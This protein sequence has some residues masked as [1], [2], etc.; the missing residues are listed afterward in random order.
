MIIDTDFSEESLGALQNSPRWRVGGYASANVSVVADGENQALACSGGI[1]RYVRETGGPESAHQRA[2]ALFRFAAEPTEM[3]LIARFI[4]DN[5]HVLAKIH[6][7][8]KSAGIYEVIGGYP[9]EIGTIAWSGG[10]ADAASL[11]MEVV[12]RRVRLWYE[13]ADRPV[14][15]RPP[16]LAADLTREPDSGE[17]GIYFSGGGNMRLLS[18]SARDIPSVV[19]PPPS[20]SYANASGLSLNFAAFTAGVSGVSGNCTDIEWEVY[21]AD[22]VDFPEA[23][24]DRTAPSVTTRTLWGRPGFAYD[25]R[26]REWMNDGSPGPWTD[27][28]RVLLPGDR[29]G[30]L[31]P[32]L[33][34]IEFPD[35]IPD[36]VLIREQTASVNATISE[37]GHERVLSRQARPRNGFKFVFQNRLHDECQLLIDFF[38]EMR[39]KKEPFAWT[40]PTNGEQFALRFD[41][42]NYEIRYDEHGDAGSIVYLAFDVMEVHIGQISTV[43]VSIGDPGQR[44]PI[45]IDSDC[46]V[47]WNNNLAAVPQSGGSPVARS[48]PSGTIL[49]RDEY[50]DLSQKV[51]SLSQKYVTDPRDPD[52]YVNYQHQSIAS[53]SDV[54]QERLDALRL[55]LQ[56]MRYLRLPLSFANHRYAT[57]WLTKTTYNDDED[58][59]V[60][61]GHIDAKWGTP[62]SLY[63]DD[64]SVYPSAGQTGSGLYLYK[65]K[66]GETDLDMEAKSLNCQP[67]FD[68]SSYAD[69]TS[70][71]VFIRAVATD[72]YGYE[73]EENTP[74]VTFHDILN[75]GANKWHRLHSLGE[76]IMGTAWLGDVLPSLGT[77]LGGSPEYDDT[78]VVP[79]SV[80]R[81]DAPASE[82]ASLTVTNDHRTTISGADPAGFVAS[83][84][85]G[86]EAFGSLTYSNTSVFDITPA[87]GAS[88][89]YVVRGQSTLTDITFK[90]CLVSNSGQLAFLVEQTSADLLLFSMVAS[91]ARFSIDAT[92]GTINDVV[93]DACSGDVEL[94]SVAGR[95]IKNCWLNRHEGQ[96]SDLTGIGINVIRGLPVGLTA[97]PPPPIARPP[98]YPDANEVMVL[99]WK[100]KDGCVLIKVKQ[101]V[102]CGYLSSPAEMP[103]TT[104]TA[105][106]AG[107]MPS[108]LAIQG[109][110]PTW[111][112]GLAFPWLYFAESNIEEETFTG[113]MPKT[114]DYEWEWGGSGLIGVY[115]YGYVRVRV[116]LDT[117]L[118]CWRMCVRNSTSVSGVGWYYE[119][120][121]TKPLGNG[122][123]GTYTVTLAEDPQW[124]SQITIG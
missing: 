31:V 36:Y 38:E 76:D 62:D 52:S 98:E 120:Q 22:P 16:D 43:L 124:P 83:A 77:L 110:D 95:S 106:P 37:T 6:N 3:G 33:P 70:A 47:Q 56:R 53:D 41:A 45:M 46:L 102:E 34:S 25:V 44:V 88:H 57:V 90:S 32:V 65:I 121:A 48:R 112:D 103:P 89:A 73:A 93:F 28:E 63:V 74:L 17:W 105:P 20:V 118:C 85:A 27:F 14:S 60:G 100:L 21:P 116:W 51:A 107:S 4:D 66:R 59:D 54:T 86:G 115:T 84:G 23:Y 26:A 42:D 113:Q 24:R 104:C 80:T 35:V 30:V 40:H 108:S 67:S 7:S 55:A 58:I 81:S 79:S 78:V 114:L 61:M 50:N 68:F 122:P 91:D 11:R 71:I 92:A 12:G 82:G 75:S 97:S 64:Y 72:E 5:T 119:V 1:N 8:D 18:F 19:M 109:Y 96:Y 39:A 111:T 69:A 13:Q 99:S 94:R 117:A 29:A 15:D 2:E 87:S 123:A 9:N 10:S 101:Q 49:S